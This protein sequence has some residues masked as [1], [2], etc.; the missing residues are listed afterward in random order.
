[1]ESP[2]NVIEIRTTAPSLEL[3]ENIADTLLQER[4]VACVQID[5][6]IDSRYW[7][8]GKLERV[9]EWR[10]LARTQSGL[11]SQVEKRIQ[12]IHTYEVPEIIVCPIIDGSRDYIEW[13]I[14]ETT[15]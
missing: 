14:K 1:M 11:Y 10:V 9:R 8:R 7:W 5:S 4:L 13:I 6:L 15:R 3:A 2:L 12:T